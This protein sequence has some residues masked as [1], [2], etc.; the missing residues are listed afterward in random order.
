MHYSSI[1]ALPPGFTDAE[2]ASVESLRTAWVDQRQML[3]KSGALGDFNARLIRRWAIETGVI[4]R[5]YSLDRGTTNI[6]VEHGLDAALIEHGAS[7]MPAAELV[8]ILNDH[9]HAAEF[10]MDHVSKQ[11]RLSLHFIKS[12]HDMLTSHQEMVEAQDQFG[13]RLQVPLR[14]GEWKLLPNN[15]TRP[16]GRLHEYCPP[17]KVQDEMDR[18]LELYAALEAQGASAVV[19]AS[20]LHH[21]FTQIHPFQDGNGRVAR[22][23]TAYVFVQSDCF[24]IVVDRDMRARYIDALEAADNGDVRP[25]VRLFAML[26][27]RE[28]EEA[29]SLAETTQLAA[30]HDS[31]GALRQQ[32][33]QALRDR[34]REKREAV[35]VQRKAVLT[36]G[37]NLF[38]VI[39][40]PTAEEFATDLSAVVEN[41]LD[42]STVRLEES[43]I[44]RQHYFKTQIVSVAQREGYYCDLETFH[45]WIR[46]RTQHR[47]EEES[48]VN[49]IVFSIHSVGRQ[50]TGVLALSAYFATRFLDETGQSKTLDPHPLAD[51]SLTFSYPEDDANIHERTREWL[52]GVI[53]LGIEHLRRSL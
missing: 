23:L 20:W 22:A 39:L 28:I 2:A 49:E 36:K 35:T 3:E 29:L 48:K 10:V 27:K 37:Q 17:I 6:L 53:N 24:P 25:L 15:P 42:G 1:D 45:R 4:E 40:K 33:L 9:R 13:N 14:R 31:G 47:D 51:R 38:D 41:E 12:L 43:S 16:D 32:L 11:R 19:R 50:F 21:R 7:D 26:Q 30:P 34:A 46:I 44:D 52:E 8:T 18:M 5:I